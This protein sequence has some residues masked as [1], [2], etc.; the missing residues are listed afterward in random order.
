MN[1]VTCLSL[2][3]A[4]FASTSQ[5]P[6]GGSA[7]LPTCLPR[8]VVGGGARGG[9]GPSGLGA[10]LWAPL[11][12]R[13]PRP[14]YRLRG[15]GL[16]TLRG[17]GRRSAAPPPPPSSA[18]RSPPRHSRLWRRRQVSAVNREIGCLPVSNLLRRFCVFVVCADTSCG[19]R[20]D[21]PESS[22][23]LNAA[24]RGGAAV[25]A[26]AP[27]RGLGRCCCDQPHPGAAGCAGRGR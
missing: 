19:P 20:T 3:W 23:A 27:Q 16:R 7:G 11:P 4:G 9:A 26:R 8:R 14:A 18:L 22:G 15:A 12:A 24:C 25:G 13:H 21:S 6:S 1:K 5:P 10:P 2:I 17:A